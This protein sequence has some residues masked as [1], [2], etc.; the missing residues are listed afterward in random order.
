MADVF[1]VGDNVNFT[2]DA[3][4]A[5]Y[6][7]TFWRAV[8]GT[9][10]FSTPNM[11]MSSARV[12]SY[13]QYRY[14]DV[15]FTLTV[16]VAPTAGQSKR[17]GFS[18]PNLG[19]RGRIEFD[20]TGA[21]FSVVAYANNGTTVLINQTITWDAAWTA[22]AVR[23]RILWGREGIQFFI[24]D[25]KVAFAQ[26]KGNATNPVV[27]NLPMALHMNNGNADNLDMAAIIAKDIQALT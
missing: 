13:S 16:P 22:T 1:I 21:V 26:I 27:P 3:Q 23:Y 9:P 17:W 14:G 11:R 6:D 5:Q 12:G 15:E 18:C 10:T 24:N 2:Y 19:N 7:T 4:I 25:V 20:I 8:T